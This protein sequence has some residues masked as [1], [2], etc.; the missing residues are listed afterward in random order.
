MADILSEEEINELLEKVDDWCEGDSDIRGYDFIFMGRN[1]GFFS[2]C[3][4]PST[5]NIFLSFLYNREELL[6]NVPF[7]EVRRMILGG[8]FELR[9]V[10]NGDR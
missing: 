2:G 5:D 3:F 6:E 10:R 9:E 1:L 7:G 4:K 8:E